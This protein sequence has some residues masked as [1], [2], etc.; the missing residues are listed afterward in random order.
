MIYKYKILFIIL[1]F[2]LKCNPSKSNDYEEKTKC[3]PVDLKQNLILCVRLFARNHVK[4]TPCERFCLKIMQKV[5]PRRHTFFYK[6]LRVRGQL[7]V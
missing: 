7:R 5:C 1:V 2:I 3:F 4:G 6:Q